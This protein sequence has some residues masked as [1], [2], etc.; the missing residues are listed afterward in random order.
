MLKRN[1]LIVT[2]NPMV[3]I[4]RLVKLTDSFLNLSN[5]TLD[6][7]WNGGDG[8]AC[9]V[10]K[11][12]WLLSIQIYESTKRFRKYNGKEIFHKKR[13]IFRQWDFRTISQPDLRLGSRTWAWTDRGQIGQW[14]MEGT[15]GL[16]ILL[17]KE[18]WK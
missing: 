9:S 11:I 12:H 3:C 13:Q 5:P 6:D 1:G 7:Y 8:I 2:V 10:G 4:Q 17:K 16:K 14:R 18:E 15:K